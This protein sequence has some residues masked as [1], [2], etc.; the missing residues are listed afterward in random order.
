MNQLPKNFVVS[1]IRI[2][3]V[4]LELL[5]NQ[6]NPFFDVEASKFGS[7]HVAPCTPSLCKFVNDDILWFDD[8]FDIYLQLFEFVDFAH[9][10]KVDVDPN[11][12]TNLYSS[13]SPFLGVEDF[14]VS[15]LPF[16][17]FGNQ[18][19]SPIS[20]ASTSNCIVV[21]PSNYITLLLFSLT[22]ILV[23]VRFF[24]MLNFLRLMGLS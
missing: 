22:M 24:Q 13:N 21:I 11:I 16:D 8:G 10:T 23:L 9:F 20:F 6:L 15:K 5:F 4:V 2:E 17:A 12:F 1:S 3:L 14:D 7:S 19:F 18:C